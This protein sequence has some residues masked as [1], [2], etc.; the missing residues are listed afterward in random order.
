MYYKDFLRYRQVWLGFALIWIMLYHSAF[1]LG[2]LQ[3]LQT[4]GYAGVDICLF[5]SGIG[6]FYSL[7]S[8]SDVVRF[9]K[10]RMKRLVPTYLVYITFWL[11]IQYFMGNREFPMILGNLFAVQFFT[12]RG[13]HFN[14]YIS[15]LFLF[16]ILA[17]YFK[18]IAEQASPVRKLLFLV[19]LV[20]LSISFWEADTYIIAATRIP[21]FY[22]GMLFANICKN[23]TPVK[24]SDVLGMIVSFI[25]GCCLLIAFFIFI[26]NRLRSY[27]LAWYPFI[28]M[29]PPLCFAISY[30]SMLLERTKNPNPIESFLS[31]CGEY[32]LELCIIHPPLFST[33]HI[34]ISEF[35]LS[36]INHWIWA[37]GILSL[38]FGCFVLRRLTALFTRLCRG[39][40]HS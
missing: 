2:P 22:V 25:L 39:Y 3:I 17:P 30:L 13:N 18:I 37:A 24:K 12:G 32:S 28:L 14:W 33:I 5:A 40:K 15:T 31:L 21:I 11:T 36:G 10:R 8:D 20:L 6:C 23:D 27:G 19:F 29:T 38:P 9:M 26:P 1:D 16:Y 35:N 7:S 4:T 34:L